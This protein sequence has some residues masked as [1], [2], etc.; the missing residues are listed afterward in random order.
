MEHLKIEGGPQDL[1]HLV[2][3]INSALERA[4]TGPNGRR[5]TSSTEAGVIVE[6]SV[7]EEDGGLRTRI[8]K[9]D[10]LVELADGWA[11]PKRCLVCGDL[12]ALLF[13]DE[14]IHSVVVD[15]KVAF[16]KCAAAAND[17]GRVV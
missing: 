13:D 15:G 14:Y 8:D 6:I 12:V 4:K 11:E 5:E 10:D 9:M 17:Q 3:T 2:A 7:L 16:V 1:R